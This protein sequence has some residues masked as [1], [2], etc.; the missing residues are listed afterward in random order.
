MLFYFTTDFSF[1]FLL[2]FTTSPFLGGMSWYVLIFDAHS[3]RR[4]LLV[5]SLTCRPWGLACSA[6]GLRGAGLLL[7][8]VGFAQLQQGLP[9]RRSAATVGWPPSQ[10][11]ELLVSNS[12]LLILVRHLLLEA[13]HLLL[14]KTTICFTY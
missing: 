6:Q 2:F 5:L 11:R 8:R 14:L 4:S 9:R 13:M 3:V 1:F 7:R 12:F 10:W